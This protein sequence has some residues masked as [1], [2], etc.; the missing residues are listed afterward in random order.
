MLKITSLTITLKKDLRSIISGFSFDLRDGD[1]AVIIGEE[2]DGKSTLLKAIYDPQLIESYAEISGDINTRGTRLGYLPQAMDEDILALTVSDYT[3]GFDGFWDLSP[4]DIA[5]YTAQL[6]LPVGFCYSD[7]VIGTLSGGEQ[8]KLNLLK[9][10]I[11][12]PDVYLLDEPSNDIDIDALEFLEDF[13]N[14]SIKPVLFV[15]HDE[16]LIENTANVIIHI[17]QVR[18]KQVPRATVVRM[19]YPEYY[20]RRIAAFHRQSQLAAGERAEL[21]KKLDRY[22]RIAQKVE[23][24]QNVIS[25]GDPHGGQLLK[26]K[27][28]AVKAQEKRLDKEEE[29]LTDFPDLEEAISLKFPAECSVPA[30][31]VIIDITV[32]QLTVGEGEDMRVLAENLSLRVEGRERVCIVGKNGTGKSTF[33]KLIARELL[34]RCD[35]NAGYMPQ[36]YFDLL[37]KDKTPV[38]FIAPSGKKEDVTRARTLLGSAKF[39]PNEMESL[40]SDVS[41]GQKAKCAFIKLIFDRCNVLVLDEPTRNLSPLSGPVIR[42]ILNEFGGAI[43]AVS[44]DRK[45]IEE[46][47]DRCVA[48]EKP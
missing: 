32:P 20:E 1:K 7:G 9:L 14:S 47:A 27:M 12:N 39:T 21:K 6:S 44:H 19:S 43:I 30:G 28:H 40:L 18:K 26:K 5:A 31:K 13:I 8:T 2:G 11:E 34:S 41:G 23:H 22:N 16:T 33:L 37:P 3:A 17:E 15:S 4:A 25:R 38:E 29:N 24:Q 48:I 10:L 45:F 46:V 36:N 42:G 35:V